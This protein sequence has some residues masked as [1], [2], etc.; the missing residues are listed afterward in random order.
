[1]RKNTNTHNKSSLTMLETLGLDHNDIINR[2]DK[3]R[4]LEEIVQLR[5]KE[6]AYME[7]NIDDIKKEHKWEK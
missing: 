5:E 7:K 6:I 3:V 4:E 1:M 2:L